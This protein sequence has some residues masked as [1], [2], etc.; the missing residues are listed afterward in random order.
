MPPANDNLTNAQA[1][2]GISGTVTGNNQFATTETGEPAPVSGVLSGAS[3]WY[4]WTAPMTRMMDFDTHNSTDPFGNTLDTVMAVYS[5]PLGAGPQTYASLTLVTN[6]DDD[7][8]TA[9]WPGVSRVNFVAIAGTTYLIQLQGKIVS[10][11]TNEGYIVLNW[12]PAVAAGTISFATNLYNFSES[13]NY[14]FYDEIITYGF[15]NYDDELAP[16]LMN[17]NAL[18]M[19]T[20]IGTTATTGQGRVTLVR[21]GG[22]YGRMQVDLSLSSDTYSNYYS[23]NG[24]ITTI[25][26]GPSDDLGNPLTGPDTN[27]TI[28]ETNFE[29]TLG[30]DSGGLTTSLTFTNSVQTILSNTLDATGYATT[31]F[32][33]IPNCGNYVGPPKRIGQ[34][35]VTI[36]TNTVG[37]AGG[38]ASTTNYIV[39]ST[40]ITLMPV[41]SLGFLTPSAIDG[42]DFYSTDFQ[43]VTFDHYQMSKDAFVNIAPLTGD[44]AGTAGAGGPD[45]PDIL[46]NNVYPGIPRR[47][48]LT[49][50]NP[51]LDPLESLDV[52]GPTLATNAILPDGVGGVAGGGYVYGNGITSTALSTNTSVAE[53]TIQD[54]YNPPPVTGQG[55]CTTYSVFNFERSTF[56]THK[57]PLYST[58]TPV[59]LFVFREGP[60]KNAATIN[61]TVNSVGKSGA[62]GK[63]AILVPGSDYAIGQLAGNTV[64]LGNYDFTIPYQTSAGNGTVTFA[65]NQANTQPSTLSIIDNNNGAVEFDME[66]EV[67]LSLPSGASSTDKIGNIGVADVTILFDD[68]MLDINGNITQQQPGGAADRNWNP[69]IRL[70]P[71]R[72]STPCLGRT[73]RWRRSPFRRM[74]N[75]SWAAIFGLMIRLCSLTWC[76][77]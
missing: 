43:T 30:Y 31:F 68:N 51:R 59:T 21:T 65:A 27:M 7:V 9:S 6:N 8:N 50:S 49:L 16:S 5:L 62:W 46:G 71:C 60:I 48:I 54:F 19:A 29:F 34:L 14:L 47:I 69:K 26:I 57:P 28:W 12:A 2:L 66:Y 41:T 35:P 24:W 74:E 23:T 52:A 42:T 40:N 45:Y 63:P 25:Y 33:N 55:P 53:M 73:R 36:V 15:N 39:Y 18:T 56:R 13:D 44:E 70:F 10:G 20:N 76:G 75:R 58:N 64:P 32:T 1:I 22:Y 61:Y 38:G 77:R 3:I 4:L 72:P 37:G 17:T 67:E 11:T